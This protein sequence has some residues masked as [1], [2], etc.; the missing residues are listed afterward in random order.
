MIRIITREKSAGNGTRATRNYK[1]REDEAILILNWLLEEGYF[2][3]QCSEKKITLKQLLGSET[4]TDP[5]KYETY[6]VFTGPIK[7]MKNLCAKAK[8][9]KTL[10]D[11]LLETLAQ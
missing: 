1:I 2:V 8:A 11:A 4:E 3:L 6:Q 9:E 7:E 10:F 5:L